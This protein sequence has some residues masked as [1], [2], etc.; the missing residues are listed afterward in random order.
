MSDLDRLHEAFESGA[1]IRPDATE[2]NFIDLVRAV[3]A[4]AG[5]DDL[6]RSP[7]SKAMSSVIGQPDH[8]VFV[9]ADGLGTHFIEDELGP[10]SWLARHLV[11]PIQSVY[12]STTSTAITSLA[13]GCWPATHAVAGWWNYLPQLGEPIVVLPFLRLSDGAPL[14]DCSNLTVADAIPLAPLMQ[15]MPRAA[16]VVQPRAIINSAYSTFIGGDAERIPYNNLSQAVAA[17]ARRIRDSHHPTHTYWYIPNVDRE[18]H[19]HSCNSA[20]VRAALRE[21]DRAL[22]ALADRLKGTSSRIVLTADHGHLDVGAKIPLAADDSLCDHLRAAPSGDMRISFFHVRDG[23]FGAFEGEFRSRFGEHFVLITTDQLDELRLLGPEP[24]SEETRRRVGDYAAIA[25]D[26]AVL[27]Y[28]G[29]LDGDH[30]M[31]QR[32]H[33]SGLSSR[34]MTV[35]LIVG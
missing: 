27:R 20:E 3:A 29:D 17:I 35:P 31:H 8:L 30:F 11:Q 10:R 5:I 14:Q 12:P 32:S 26:A 13:T 25:L 2:P 22:A 9:L 1:R 15:R 34:E 18:A 19:E 6:D 21:L 28:T 7:H 4:L 16:A 23:E 24:L 33:H